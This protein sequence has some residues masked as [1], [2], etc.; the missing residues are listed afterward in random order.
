MPTGSFEIWEKMIREEVLGTDMEIILAIAS[1]APLIDYFHEILHTGNLLISLVGG[2]LNRQNNR[3]M[4]R[5]FS[6]GSL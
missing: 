5:C 1:A 3:R 6:G 2:I 4:S